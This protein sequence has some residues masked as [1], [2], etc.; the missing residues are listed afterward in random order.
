MDGQ[1]KPTQLG[2]LERAS[3]NHWT[4]RSSLRNVVVFCLLHT[5]RWTESKISP[6]V[7]CNIHHRQNPFKASRRYIYIYIYIYIY[8]FQIFR[9]RKWCV[10]IYIYTYHEITLDPRV[11]GRWRFMWWFSGLWDL[12]FWYISTSK[13]EAV[14]FAEPLQRLFIL[15]ILDGAV[16]QKTA[17]WAQIICFFP[18]GEN[19]HRTEFSHFVY[20]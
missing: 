6:I 15:T 10:Y 7:L 14:Y 2:P 1:D 16:T 4:E 18:L 17:M 5:R 8:R 19:Y 12:V 13:M 11:S 20:L 9:G 3:L